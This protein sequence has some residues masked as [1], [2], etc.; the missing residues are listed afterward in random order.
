M[1]EYKFLIQPTTNGMTLVKFILSNIDALNKTNLWVDIKIIDP[2]DFD[3]SLVTSLKKSGIIGFPAL[4]HDDNK[5]KTGLNACM[6]VL[7]ER[8]KPPVTRNAQMGATEYERYQYMQ[9]FGQDDH[10]TTAPRNDPEEEE[11]GLGDP[12]RAMA[13]FAQ[14]RKIGPPPGGRR[15][16]Q[17]P[18]TNHRNP[19]PAQDEDY[20]PDNIGGGQQQDNPNDVHQAPQYTPEA[21]DDP[22]DVRMMEALMGNLPTQ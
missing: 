22:L 6:N 16:P 1:T 5:P 12:S 13:S 14:R 17:T 15:P 9:C 19:P 20:P 2:K 11:K 3:D 7:K 10:G 8:L 21:G 18:A 4:I